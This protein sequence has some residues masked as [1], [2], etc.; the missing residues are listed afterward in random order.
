[1]DLT[2][3]ADR[4]EAV[5][6]RLT[7]TL[8]VDDLAD[9]NACVTDLRAATAPEDPAPAPEPAPAPTSDYQSNQAV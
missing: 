8:G 1:M 2:A 7:P 6:Q 5:V 9:L 3:T 4:L